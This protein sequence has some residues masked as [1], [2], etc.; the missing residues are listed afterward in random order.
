MKIS[1]V[2]RWAAAA[3]IM[4][5]VGLTAHAGKA[6]NYVFVVDCSASMTGMEGNENIWEATKDRLH[7]AITAKAKDPETV[8]TV[9]PF[10]GG[11]YEPWTFRDGDVDWKGLEKALDKYVKQLTGTNIV[12]AFK[13]AQT[14]Y[15]PRR[16]NTIF[17]FTDGHD[18]K[19]G[20]PA[21]ISAIEQWCGS[22]PDQHLN[23][24]M[25]TRAAMDPEL[26][27]A[28][29]ACDDASAITPD[30]ITEDK[31]LESFDEVV[32]NANTRDLD[33]PQYMT[34]S[35]NDAIPTITNTDPYFR[36]KALTPIRNHNFTL[37]ISPTDKDAIARLDS[38]LPDRKVPY[39]FTFNCDVDG[40]VVTNP[41]IKVI[42]TRLPQRALFINDNSYNE[43]N[44]GEVKYHP[45]FLWSEASPRAKAVFDLKAQYNDDAQA[46]NSRVGVVLRG[47]PEKPGGFTATYNGRPLIGDTAFIIDSR[48]HQSILEVTFD[49]EAA[50]GTR[51]LS[52]V[53]MA[54]VNI[55][56]IN[57]SRAKK[58]IP[59]RVRYTREMNT[60]ACTLMWIGIA[61]AIAL[62][63]W[64]IC[65]RRMM[66]PQF[67]KGLL[68]LEG[69]GDYY[70]TVKLRG[71]RKVVYTSRRGGQG[72]LSR[73]FT[74]PIRYIRSE[75][76]AQP[77]EME[78]ASR[79]K[80]RLR[81]AG[82][83]ASD[84]GNVLTPG[85]SA[86]LINSASGATTEITYN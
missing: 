86:R 70:Q 30:Q 10:Q 66:F 4:M 49:P 41:V 24:V 33:V 47:D 37:Q 42:M 75:V 73:L 14:Y 35:G 7:Q 1:S 25:L 69:P 62:A 83:Y 36:V 2:W 3:V 18:N 29:K 74:G 82:R 17:L 43:A 21:L 81:T 15:D 40:E 56:A 5:G 76:W 61:L 13:K 85:T 22:H 77:W 52:L 54:A 58:A 78:P 6:Y 23:Y 51:Y 9:I 55:D 71:C 26:Q 39:E 34:Y 84:M 38:A 67:K 27:A 8:I 72:L 16:R 31:P 32:L 44:L 65:L 53:P 20:T 19:Q 28:L 60:L 68:T 46:A 48:E 64:F 11:Y 59:L 57:G 50:T 63:V 80:I 79:N 45:D 12:G